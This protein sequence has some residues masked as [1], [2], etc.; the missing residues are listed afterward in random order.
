MHNK[1]AALP[2]VTAG[3]WALPLCCRVDALHV[4][5]QNGQGR[6]E[7]HPLAFLFELSGSMLEG[8]GTRAEVR[9]AASLVYSRSSL[10][11][12]T[13]LVEALLLVLRTGSYD[14]VQ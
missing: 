9:V 13:V 10:I 11:V 5:G 6:L 12:V 14:A 8:T 3:E 7:A 1:V 4:D 2:T